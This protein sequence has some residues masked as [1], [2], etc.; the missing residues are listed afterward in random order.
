[1]RI[2]FSACPMYGHINTVLPLA[3]A[4]R[5]A[6]HQVAVATG[7][8]LV[9]HVERRGLVA[10]SAGPTHREAGGGPSTDWL[11]YFAASAEKRAVDLVPR[12]AQWRPDIVVS[13]ETELAGPVAAAVAGA[14]H[15]VHGL[16]IMP[17]LRIWDAFAVA[18]QQLYG[19]WQ[20][21]LNAEVVRGATYVEICP[22]AL[23]PVGERIWRYAL[24][25]RPAVG[26]AVAGEELPEALDTLPYS[27]TVHLTLGT[28]F[29]HNRDVL[30]IALAGLRALP[31]NVVV[32]AGPGVD[33]G[34]FGPQPAHVLIVSYVP[35]SLLLPRCRVVVSHGGAG[36][37]FGALAH[38]TPQL[39]IPQGAEQ[40]LN[41]EAC[42]G[43]G[44]ALSLP[45]DGA[46][47]E[48]VATAVR[49]LLDDASFTAAAEAVR[50]EIEAMPDAGT[51]LA[52]ITEA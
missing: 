10:W 27:D 31:V 28:V 37:M 6:G 36:V 44:A 39:I 13:E 3:L 19:Q 9:P 21:S 23:R 49:R 8:D 51:V 17:P 25:S 18:I 30:E 14:R 45:P 34:E 32:A 40:F 7:S 29:H 52:A 1:M 12:A 2:L 16:G 24:P 33:P 11:E 15:V 47:A 22:P 5:E 26:G 4:A 42:E 46:T 50:V 41:A 20:V 43:A 48:A 38:G 35:H